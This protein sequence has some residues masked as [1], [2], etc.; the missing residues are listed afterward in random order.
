MKRLGRLIL[1]L[2]RELAD[3]SA[4]ERYLVTQGR[5][6][7]REE[8]RKFSDRRLQSKYARAKCC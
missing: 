1:A 3:E 4:Y 5:S 7:S 2:L 6:H 8:W